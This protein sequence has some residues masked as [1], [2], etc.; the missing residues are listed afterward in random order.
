MQKS[1]KQRKH[2]KKYEDRHEKKKNEFPLF[3]SL[4]M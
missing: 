4:Q 2:L 1:L 3:H